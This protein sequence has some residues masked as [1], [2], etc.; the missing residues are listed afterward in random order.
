M[1]RF[2][3]PP[4]SV[5]F[6]ALACPPLLFAITTLLPPEV[7]A[8]AGFLVG[9][10]VQFFC[11]VAYARWRARQRASSGLQVQVTYQQQLDDGTLGPYRVATVDLP[12]GAVIAAP[13]R[14]DG[15]FDA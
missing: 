2:P 5:W 3:R 6:A 8:L 12:E 7:R 14:R 1:I 4:A 9:V 15:G 10:V 11:N 13:P